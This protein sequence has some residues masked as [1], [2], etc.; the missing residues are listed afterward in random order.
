[1][2]DARIAAA[3]AALALAACTPRPSANIE[4][5]KTPSGPTVRGPEAGGE[6]PGDK[7]D[8]PKTRWVDLSIESEFGCAVER[9]GSVYCWGR[10][11][12][13]EMKL[14]EIPEQPDQNSPPYYNNRAWGPASRIEHIHDARALSTSNSRACAI[15]EGGRIRC[16]GAV[17]WGS[18]HVYDVAE[19]TGAVALEVGDG[20]SCAALEDGSLWCWGAEDFGVPKRRL[21]GAIAMSVRDGLACGLTANGE[22]LCWGQTIRD[23]HRYDK[24][25]NQPQAQPPSPSPG[26][27]QAGAPKPPPKID[28]SELPDQLEVGRFRGATDLRISGWNN[29]CVLRQDGRVVCSSRDLLSLLRGE[30]LDMK[31][32]EGASEI[33]QLETTRSHSCARTLDGRVLCWGRNVYGQLGD[34][35][36]TTRETAEP[37]AELAGTVDLSLVDDFSCAATNK[38]E[39]RCWGFD[40]GEAIAHEDLHAH[41]LE[42][43][44]ASSIAAA[45]RT[46]CVVDD[47]QKL[48]CWGSDM[49]EQLGIVSASTPTVLDVDVGKRIEAI[50]PS[51]E[52]C[53][54]GG[55]G[56]LSCGTWQTFTPGTPPKLSVTTTIDDVVDLAVGPPP[57]CVIVGTGAKAELRCG[58]NVQKIEGERLVKR[59]KDV[60]AANMRACVLDGGKVN[61][62]GDLYY[63]GDAPPPPRELTKIGGIGGKVRAL[64]SSTYQDCALRT[65]GRVTCWAGR[66]ETKWSDDGRKPKS[67]TYKPQQFKELDLSGIVQ[68]VGG[69]LRLC[70]LDKGGK[71]RCWH[72]NPYDEAIRWTD[73][74]EFEGPVVELAAGN[75]HVCARQQSGKVTCWGEDTWGQLGRVPSRIYLEPTVLPID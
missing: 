73:V 28:D 48:R 2:L 1:M 34:G 6:D 68:I 72:D 47:K 33:S 49:I 26:S 67:I 8:G 66:T 38:D 4:A 25:F 18:Q 59:P 51:W 12:A 11:P 31:V 21:S 29:L 19:L 54:L 14:R 75:E 10:G 7:A 65:D 15:V 5:S 24:Q 23:W 64:T 40:R 69:G 41:T 52:A 9:T 61:C 58:Q 45:G 70:A 53:F 13:A 35:S 22:V 71:V 60:T 16:W 27:K 17:R 74:P 20:E 56:K 39:I 30:E 37:V 43:L 46:T 3:V 57:F 55:N 62:F 44:R 36:S 42:G 32:V 63:W 50:A